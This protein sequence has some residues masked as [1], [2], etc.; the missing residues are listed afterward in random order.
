MAIVYRTAGAWGAGLGVNLSPAQVDN[1]FYELV[2]RVVALESSGIQP[3]NIASVTVVGSQMTIFMEDASTFGPFTLPIAMLHWRGEWVPDEDYN[4]LDIVWVAFQG[5]YLVLRDHTADP[6]DFDPAAVDVSSNALYF[7]LMGMLPFNLDVPVSIS[8]MPADGAKIFQYIFCQECQYPSFGVGSYGHSG[9]VP[10][11][12]DVTMDVWKWWANLNYFVTFAAAG[13]TLTRADGSWVVDGF[14]AG[15]RVRVYNTASNDGEYLIDTVT[16][17]VITLDA[18]ETLV[19]EGPFVSSYL[20]QGS[21]VGNV[22]AFQNSTYNFIFT[23]LVPINIGDHLEIFAP[24][25]QD[26]TF[27]DFTFTLRFAELTNG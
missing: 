8:G 6:Y 19:D 12:S 23:D 24:T 25:P 21:L 15:Q 22:T 20:S 27:A 5:T 1:N 9:V 11:D 18:G 3:N 10:S 26:S 14:A 13:K 17:L 2:T 7:Q 16:N 4:E